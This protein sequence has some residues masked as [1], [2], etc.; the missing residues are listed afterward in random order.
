MNTYHKIPAIAAIVLLVLGST[1]TVAQAGDRHIARTRQGPH[2][3]SV[4]VQR[5]RGDGLYQRSVQRQGPA[6]RS[7]EAQ[8]SRGYDPETGTYQGSASRTVTG[9]DGQ[10]ASRSREVTREDGQATV[11]RQITGPNGRTSTYQRS[12]GD[13]QAEVVRT[14]PDGQTLSRSRSV[15]R[16]DQG[17][18]VNSQ[19]TGPRG[20][21]HERSVTYSPVGG[22]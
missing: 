16:S 17:V 9:V 7:L 11:T 3:G 22:E 1:A 20:G 15:E 13:G 18:T 21:S 19:A 5:D 4:A 2:G 12:R 8:R 10:T 14:G 6:G